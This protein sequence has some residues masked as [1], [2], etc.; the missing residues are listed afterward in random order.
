MFQRQRQR[1]EP[2]ILPNKPM[3]IAAQ[4]GPT[5]HERCEASYDGGRGYDEPAVGKAVDEAGD[6]DGGAVAD[7]GREGAGKCHEPEDDPAACHGV[8]FLCSG[9]E[10]AEDAL[11][12]YQEQD[13]EDQGHEQG[14]DGG[15]S[16]GEG[17]GQEG[18]EQLALH[19]VGG[20]ED[21]VSVGSWG[22]GALR[23]GRRGVCAP[24]GG[25]YAAGPGRPCCFWRGR[26]DG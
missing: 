12:V 8:P 20:G 25:G 9:G 10:E 11:A 23:V 1:L 4:H 14:Y 6:C 3:H 16:L 5:R 26:G 7:Q 18:L 22:R 15:D 2:L 13:P 24:G 19:F 21:L 17:E